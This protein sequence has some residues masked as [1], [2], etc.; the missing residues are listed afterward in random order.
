MNKEKEAREFAEL[1]CKLNRQQQAGLYLMIQGAEAM[2]KN[3]T[4]P[5]RNSLNQS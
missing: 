3:K 5:C 4:A 2:D 1:L